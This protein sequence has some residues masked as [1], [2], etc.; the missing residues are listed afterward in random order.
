MTEL[1]NHAKDVFNRAIEI[2]PEYGAAYYSRATLLTKM[3]QE[4]QAL[5]DIEMVQHLSN[6]NIEAFAND[7]NVWRSQQ[8]RMESVLE[9]ELDR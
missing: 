6:K 7:N 4:D 1:R 9:T 2:N 8:L 3:G 5:G